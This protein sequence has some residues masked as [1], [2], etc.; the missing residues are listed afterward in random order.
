M[1]STGTAGNKQHWEQ[2]YQ[3]KQP[4]QVSWYQPQA[5][6]SLQLI[7]QV[8]TADARLIDVGSGASGLI[9]D[10]LALGYRQLTVLDISAAALA[11]NQQRLGAQANIVNWQVADITTAQLPADS[12]DLW[13]DRAVF[14]FLTAKDERE[15]YVT[16]VLHSLK[17]G[18]YLLISCF[19]EQG[20]EK[21]SGLPV[22]RYNAQRLAAE[23]GDAFVLKQ[24]AE[25]LHNTPF[26]T[27]Q[28]FLYL[29]LQKA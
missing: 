20:P 26:G 7:Q 22:I 9:A 16:R 15:A 3:Q 19:D 11:V 4:E 5:G 8:T 1:M 21:C 13:H 18:G 23:F 17:Q 28:P 12:Y 25:E 2:V 6:L 27:V 29:L 24:Q 14:H 10:L